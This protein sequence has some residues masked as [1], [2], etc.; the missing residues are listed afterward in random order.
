MAVQPV[1]RHLS[2]LFGA[3]GGVRQQP[4]RDNIRMLS[5]FDGLNSL[6]RRA[7]IVKVVNASDSTRSYV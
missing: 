7:A 5:A 4:A 1:F 2:A 3:L 6:H